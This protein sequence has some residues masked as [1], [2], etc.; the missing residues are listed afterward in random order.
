MG[1]QSRASVAER[2]SVKRLDTRLEGPILV[3]PNVLG[4]ERGFFV[5][6]LVWPEIEV[7][8]CRV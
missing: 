1:S 4:D 5:E 3:A 8:S 6:T 7:L 2:I